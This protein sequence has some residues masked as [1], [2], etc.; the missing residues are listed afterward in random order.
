M[1]LRAPATGEVEGERYVNR[2][3][4]RKRILRV[5]SEN[6]LAKRWKHGKER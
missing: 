3:G 5:A 6:T 2:L 1:M 4:V